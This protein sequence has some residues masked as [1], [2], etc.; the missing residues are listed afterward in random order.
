[1]CPE[2]QN[3]GYKILR[4]SELLDIRGRAPFTFCE[5]RIHCHLDRPTHFLLSDRSL[6]GMLI[7]GRGISEIYLC[8][9]SEHF[10]KGI[11]ELRA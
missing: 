11:F 7:F 1:M 3:I 2:V 6:Y 8:V 4:A 5:Q 9:L 10:S